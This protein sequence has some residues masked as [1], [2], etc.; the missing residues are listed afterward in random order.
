L[1]ILLSCGAEE[2]R[3]R[4]RSRFTNGAIDDFLP[5]RLVHHLTICLGKGVSETVEGR[6]G[7]KAESFVEENDDP[8]ASMLVVTSNM[9]VSRII[10]DTNSTSPPGHAI[11]VGAPVQSV[12]S[13]VSTLL[14]ASSHDEKKG[15]LQTTKSA[16]QDA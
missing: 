9:E 11:S 2:S 12:A 8:L 4:D 16:T 1:P 6:G 7:R 5:R 15:G 10:L 13:C 14:C 3:G